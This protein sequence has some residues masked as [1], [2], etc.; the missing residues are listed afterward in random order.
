MPV[1]P[2][3]LQD[4]ASTYLPRRASQSRFLMV[5]GLRYHVRIWEPDPARPCAGDLLMLHGWMDVGASFQFLVDAMAGNWR[6]L[7]PD[8]RGY[9]QTDRPQADCYW[10]QDYL[11][12]MDELLRQL[13]GDAPMDIIGHSMGGNVSML[14]AG[15]RPQRVR[16]LINLEGVGMRGASADKAPERYAQWMDEL[17]AGARMHD[18]ASHEE[19]AARLM[20]N[21][22]RLAA[23]KAR[24]LAQHWSAKGAGG[25]Y[26]ILGDPA[27]KHINPVLYRVDE[28]VACWRLISAPV[29]LV[30]ADRTDQ[31][32]AFIESDEFRQR[33]SVVRS[34]EKT[35][36]ANTGHMLH[37]DQPLELARLVEAFLSRVVPADPPAADAVRSTP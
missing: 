33:L 4:S 23:D 7:A 2:T 8:W 10:F 11:A 6:V 16:R 9:G 27:H 12:D 15:I 3:A 18:Y 36:L 28:V 34:L 29:L 32:H 24:F 20:K 14:Y 35:K 5:R 26:E 1:L 17:R 13:A 30:L 19:V 21:N 37:H 22:P 31:W 25:R